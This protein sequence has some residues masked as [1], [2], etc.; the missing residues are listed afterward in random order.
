MRPKTANGEV[1]AP[2]P[3][4]A[5]RGIDVTSPAEPESPLA[6][7]NH[8]VLS[9]KSYVSSLLAASNSSL[10]AFELALEPPVSNAVRLDHAVPFQSKP[11]I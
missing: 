11:D 10:P 1:I 2:A 9:H 7:Q 8:L 4:P 3:P 6:Y 5:A